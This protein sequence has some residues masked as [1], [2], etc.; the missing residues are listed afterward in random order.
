MDKCKK[1]LKFIQRVDFDLTE[2]LPDNITKD[3]LIFDDSCEETS[4]FY[5]V[6]NWY[7]STQI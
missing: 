7:L 1:K 3:Q 6:K 4:Y 2:N 5:L